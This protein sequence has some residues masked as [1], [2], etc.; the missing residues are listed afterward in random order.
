MK[1]TLQR[2]VLNPLSMLVFGVLLGALS[3]IFDVYTQ[4]LGDV[5][6]QVAIWVLLG[7]VIAI[8]SPTRL[9]AALNIL[10][11]CLGML[12]A[13]YVTAFLTKSEALWFVNWEV[14]KYWTVFAFLTPV[15]AVAAWQTKESGVAAKLIGVGI[16][17]ASVLSSVVLFEGFRLYD[18]V[19]DGLLVY[20]IFFKKINR[21]KPKKDCALDTSSQV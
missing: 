8:Y 15:A 13:Y 1:K 2:I 20:F 18:F 21:S 9:R 7:T 10:P 16:V 6:S 14:I 19:I 4:I 3:R 11:F 17:A 12:A 5:F